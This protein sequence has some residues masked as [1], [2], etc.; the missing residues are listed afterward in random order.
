MNTCWHTLGSRL[1]SVAGFYRAPHVECRCKWLPPTNGRDSFWRGMTLESLYVYPW[2][3]VIWTANPTWAVHTVDTFVL[4][5][6]VYTLLS[7]LLLW[8]VTYEPGT[9]QA[10]LPGE[11][12]VFRCH[13]RAS[14]PVS[15]KLSFPISLQI[16]L[17]AF[18]GPNNINC[19]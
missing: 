9:N 18:L 19:L 13:I 17:A 5:R 10:L 14:N 2:V 6:V 8:M 15:R 1:A 16:V 7:W 12:N 4:F 3:Q 11:G